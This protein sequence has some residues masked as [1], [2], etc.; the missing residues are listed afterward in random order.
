MTIKFLHR[1]KILEVLLSTFTTFEPY[2][3]FLTGSAAE[4]SWTEIIKIV[5]KQYV[6]NLSDAQI[7]EMDWTT[8]CSYLKGNPV[9]VACQIDHIF[10]KL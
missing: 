6:E 8:N 3:F 1:L 9:T 5:A 7:N 10:K 2:T 4:F